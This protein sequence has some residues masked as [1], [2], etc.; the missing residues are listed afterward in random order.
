MMMAGSF[1]G[2][3]PI[4]AGLVLGVFAALVFGI[5][6]AIVT[7]SQELAFGPALAT[8]V[9]LAVYVWPRIAAM[10][11]VRELLFDGRVIA[12]FSCTEPPFFLAPV[13]YC[14]SYAAFPNSK[15]G[16]SLETVP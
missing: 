6:R 16:L 13:I 7:G 3:Q 5:L 12:L 10:Q 1:L 15:Q 4:L 2:W 14:A 8:G 11:Q 9:M